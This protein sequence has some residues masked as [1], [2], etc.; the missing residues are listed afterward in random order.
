M[1]VDDGKDEV[2]TLEKLQEQITNLNKG[3]G[4]YRDSAQKADEKATAAEQ[5]AAAAEAKAAAL[6]QEIEGLKGVKDG[7]EI[8][9]NPKDQEKLEAWAKA[10]G[11]VTK[12]EMEKQRVAVFQDS[13]AGAEKQA[14]DEFLENYPEYSNK[15]NWEKLKKEF[16]QYKQPTTLSGY[17]TILSKIHKDLSVESEKI[18]EIRA[19][20][21]QKKRLG[22][23][24]SGSAAD[25][26]EDAVTMEKLRERYPNLSEEQIASTLTE[27]NER[28]AERAK[29][30]AAKKK[31]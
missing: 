13:V 22:L 3:I 25:N 2:P 7:K 8:Q 1:A 28:A 21:E 14:V 11:F 31:K 5:K 15:D 16:E 12:A 10:Q 6:S 20:D 26:A 29:K 30:N 4:D 27:I 24:G 9:L 19:K 18:E 23:G 17:K